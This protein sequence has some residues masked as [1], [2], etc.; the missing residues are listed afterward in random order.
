MKIPVHL[1][2]HEEAE[3]KA[4]SEELAAAEEAVERAEARHQEAVQGLEDA[5]VC[6]VREWEEDDPEGLRAVL[7][8]EAPD[9]RHFD[10]L[11]RL[12]LAI[13]PIA[14]PYR[15][16][17]EGRGLRVRIGLPDIP[18]KRIPWC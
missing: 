13:K 17:A 12:G 8:P 1:I 2:E 15:W 4:A 18:V 11:E 14:K 9:P 5:Q 10:E 6:A 16:T 7:Q 3:L